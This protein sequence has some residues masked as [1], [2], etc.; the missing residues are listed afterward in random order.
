MDTA[1]EHFYWICR[2]SVQ[3]SIRRG[4]APLF[5]DAFAEIWE[6]EPEFLWRRC[7]VFVG[8]EAAHLIPD[9]MEPLLEI[10]G[11][12]N[13][14]ASIGSK[15]E[16]KKITR[17]LCRKILIADKFQDAE[18][19]ASL[20]T[21]RDKLGIREAE[22]PPIKAKQLR[23]MIGLD[24][25]MKRS[26]EAAKKTWD[27][28]VS[29]AQNTSGFSTRMAQACR[30]RYFMRGM[31][32]ECDKFLA[33]MVLV[34]T[35]FPTMPK[36]T[37]R[38]D[39]KFIATGKREL[40]LHSLDQHT[41]IGAYGL[42]KAASRLGIPYEKLAWWNFVE[43]SAVVDRSIKEAFWFPLIRKKTLGA[44]SEKRSLEMRRVID[45]EIRARAKLGGIKIRREV[46][47]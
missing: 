22:L 10:R 23:M 13:K 33:S 39:L 17:G 27:Y 20:L 9:I 43:R 40:P 24:S 12:F 28:L 6:V 14:S 2:S 41:R 7:S 30:Y 4:D 32:R 42:H 29:E 34:L 26:P 8:E 16:A 47:D 1:A 18:G 15:E 11:F 19:L 31:D 46:G 3:K 45:E 44:F 35:E 21:L 25:R 36:T 5:E 38:R 37:Y